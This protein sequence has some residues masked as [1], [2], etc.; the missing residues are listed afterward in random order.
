MSRHGWTPYAQ[1]V[2][3]CSVGESARSRLQKTLNEA[4]NN[5]YEAT[6]VKGCRVGSCGNEWCV[7]VR[8]P[9]TCSN[10][11]PKPNDLLFVFG[12]EHTKEGTVSIFAP[13]FD[14]AARKAEKLGYSENI[15]SQYSVYLLSDVT[16]LL[17]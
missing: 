2:G 3:L 9:K 16:A 11:P 17:N 14:T 5:G 4:E 7:M 12:Y 1:G 6:F 13:D 15:Q 8:K 10:Q